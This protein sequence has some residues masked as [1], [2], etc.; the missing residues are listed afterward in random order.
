SVNFIG[1]PSMTRAQFAKAPHKTIVGGSL[2]IQIPTG[3]YDS[4]RLVNL[5]NHRYAFKP[6]VGVSVPAG[7]WF[8]DAYV[9][10][11]FFTA[12][13]RFY[14]GDARRTQD[15]LT[16]VQ[17]HASY[18]FESRAWVAFDAIWYGGGRSSVDDGAPT[19][20]QSTT[21]IGATGSIP[22]AP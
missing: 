8:L 2:M 3:Q 9:G 20:R 6:E 10:A 4:S 11:W 21:R 5:G 18:T 17:A 7:R 15:P 1:P 22:L 19:D 14:P 16:S 13:D 12:N